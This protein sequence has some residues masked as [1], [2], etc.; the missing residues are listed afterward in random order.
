MVPQASTE[1]PRPSREGRP[2]IGRGP[3][4]GV[5]DTCACIIERPK[6]TLRTVREVEALIVRISRGLIRRGAEPESFAL[7]RDSLSGFGPTDG[8]EA[9]VIARRMVDG[10]LELVAMT[11]WRDLA[12]MV[13]MMG[14]DL[15][16]P[17]WLP[18]LGPLVEASSVE[19]LEI[20]RRELHRPH[21]SRPG[22][23][24]PPGADPAGMTEHRPAPDV[25][26]D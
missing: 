12:S 19:Y 22:G 20:D 6:G 3:G 8:L 16:T 26:R 24:R 1:P 5:P 13:A 15:Q 10:Q 14:P 2:W 17:S 18:S 21:R 4:I 9:F 25:Q 23:R 11:G 7:L